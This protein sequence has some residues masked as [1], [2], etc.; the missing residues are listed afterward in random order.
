M[1]ILPDTRGATIN[2]KMF[3]FFFLPSKSFQPI[4]V[5]LMCGILG[6]QRKII[7]SYHL[8]AAPQNMVMLRNL[9]LGNVK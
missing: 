4:V 6:L 1:Y 7:Y 5:Y 2:T 8:Q 3:F 9:S